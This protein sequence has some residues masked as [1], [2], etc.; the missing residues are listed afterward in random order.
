MLGLILRAKFNWSWGFPSFCTWTKA[1]IFSGSLSLHCFH[2]CCCPDPLAGW[3]EDTLY[4]RKKWF[5]IWCNPQL[6]NSCPSVLPPRTE[7]WNLIKTGKALLRLPWPLHPFIHTFMH[8]AEILIRKLRARFS[9]RYH[10]KALRKHEIQFGEQASIT[11]G[12]LR[13]VIPQLSGS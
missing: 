9:T 3:E 6:S 4:R 11:W 8:S 5:W 12:L 13:V 10:Q 7:S 1:I 2:G